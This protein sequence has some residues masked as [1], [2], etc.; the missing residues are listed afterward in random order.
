MGVAR[1][2][3]L[4]RFLNGDLQVQERDE[5]H[6]SFAVAVRQDAL[7]SGVTNLPRPRKFCAVESAGDVYKYP[8]LML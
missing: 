1:G 8:A 2:T 3:K 5:H 7:F 4:T 6:V